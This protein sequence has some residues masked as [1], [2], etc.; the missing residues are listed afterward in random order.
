MLSSVPSGVGGVCAR[1]TAGSK[2]ASQRKKSVLIAGYKE[3]MVIPYPGDRK[4]LRR[5]RSWVCNSPSTLCPEV[6]FLSIAEKPW[7]R[8]DAVVAGE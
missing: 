8:Y 5:R 3:N 4:K 2:K 6:R 1:L 7:A